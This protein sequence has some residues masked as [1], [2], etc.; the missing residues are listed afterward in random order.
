MTITQKDNL[1]TV[2]GAE[3]AKSNLSELY[4]LASADF[5]A[6]INSGEVHRVLQI[7]KGVVP[8]SVRASDALAA[9]Y[10][11]CVGAQ[12]SHQM[13]CDG[14][15]GFITTDHVAVQFSVRKVADQPDIYRVLF[16]RVNAGELAVNM[17]DKLDELERRV[18]EVES[19]QR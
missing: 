8:G 19:K 17:K 7:A 6:S 14:C 4:L 1:F 12:T 15:S 13:F 10:N 2:L 9:H 11:L 16:V 5:S 18:N 3:V